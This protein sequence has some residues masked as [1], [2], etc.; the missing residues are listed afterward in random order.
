[1]E[2]IASQRLTGRPDPAP[3]AQPDHP[4]GERDHAG[5]C[6]VPGLVN[7]AP[8]PVRTPSSDPG[9]VRGNR[10]PAEA[11][12]APD[13]D[14]QLLPCVARRELRKARHA[15]PTRAPAEPLPALS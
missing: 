4:R 13:R 1:M 11:A 6:E 5:Q 14:D 10:R 3:M 2:T 15:G 8:A 12:S 9:Q 7:V